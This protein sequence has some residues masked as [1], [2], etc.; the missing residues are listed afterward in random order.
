MNEL[1]GFYDSLQEATGFDFRPLPIQSGSKKPAVDS[2]TDLQ[3]DQT[4]PD[5]YRDT[6]QA[7]GS[8]HGNL[9]LIVPPGIVVLDLD[10]KD[11]T[12]GAQVLQR[13]AQEQDIDLSYL[14]DAPIV[15]TPSGGLHFYFKDPEGTFEQKETGY[16]DGV[17]IQAGVSGCYVLIPDSS[18]DQGS[19]RW[20][21]NL[22]TTPIPK[23]RG[24]P[25]PNPSR[26]DETDTEK[27][28]NVIPEGRRNDTLTSKAGQ[29]RYLGMDQEEIEVALQALNRSRC[30]PSLPSDEVA[31]IAKS[32]S[33]YEPGTSLNLNGSAQGSAEWEPPVPLETTVPPPLP[34]DVLPPWLEDFTRSL[35]E[36]T[37]TPQALGLL[38]SLSVVSTAL[39]KK[40]VIQVKP[41][42]QE[43]LGVWTAVLLPPGTRKS[44]VFQKIIEPI[45]DYEQK[46]E[47]IIQPKRQEALNK[48]DVLDKRIR[49]L[50]KQA[51]KKEDPRE[52][53]EVLRELNKVQEE[54]DQLEIPTVPQWIIQDVTPE[55]LSQILAEQGGKVACLSPE[56]DLLK[57][58][59]GR[60]NRGKPNVEAIKKAW[61]GNE[62]IRD[63]RI[64]RD[65]TFVQDPCLTVGVTVQPDVIENI[66]NKT[67]MRGEGIMARFL[68]AVP[69]PRL[70][71]RK[72]GEDVPGLDMQAY[73]QYK[74]HLRHLLEASPKDHR[75][76]EMVPHTLELSPDARRVRNEFEAEVEAMFQDGGPLQDIADWG[77]KLV[78]QT[79]RISGLI[80]IAE[81]VEN[82]FPLWKDPITGEAMQ[83]AV[84]LARH[85]IGHARHVYE[86]METDPDVLLAQYVWK[87]IRESGE[88]EL[89][90]RELH[91]LTQGKTQIQKVEDLQR[92]L[93]I[94]EQQDLI[95]VQERTSDGKGRNPSPLIHVNP[96]DPEPTDTNDKNDTNG[97]GSDG[98]ETVNSVNN[99][100]PSQTLKPSSSN[101]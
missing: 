29:L 92:P 97:F 36:F 57:I 27:D 70:G 73:H 90:K 6:L 50:K 25:D 100:S 45:E 99:V 58:V 52:R 96:Q 14:R 64:E 24:F 20:V 11:G 43:P 7:F 32:V 60:Y 65:A 34:L 85:L 55:R 16:F 98:S 38:L 28:P 74:D 1:V 10:R 82:G 51:S 40:G 19:Y 89:T 87:R 17:D 101:P 84:R 35:S 53:D 86:R 80:H 31:S 5:E 71:Q 79:V 95:R 75:D 12:N 63:D 61:T 69:E 88:T 30:Q 76:G 15:R 93:E 4:T 33:R 62:A 81:L 22:I 83:R 72:T 41:G 13:R 49:K 8:H 26:K 18:T 44:P 46:Q 54:R 56:G 47:E 42:Y 21:H 2:W 9:A 77:G 37:Q 78:G 23:I 39:A 91:R 59:A 94:L 3:R 66:Q 67:T 68:Y 48:K